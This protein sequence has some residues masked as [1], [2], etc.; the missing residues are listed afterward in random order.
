M[1]RIKLLEL[2]NILL[3]INPIFCDDYIKQILI[4]II[5]KEYNKDSRRLEIMITA[6]IL[7]LLDENWIKYFMSPSTNG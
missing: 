5:D 2:K 6:K 3:H 7:Q 1:K 4:S